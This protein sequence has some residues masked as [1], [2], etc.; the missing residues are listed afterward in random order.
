[1]EE[2]GASSAIGRLAV[3]IGANDS[4]FNKKMK[5][6]EQAFNR[7]A[8]S[9]K[10]TGETLTKAFTGPLAAVGGS[11]LAMAASAGRAADRLLDLQDITG[12]SAKKLQEFQHVA[13]VA[14]V[15]T[16]AVSN[17][18][19]NLTRRLKGLDSEGAKSSETLARL[20][21]KTHDAA[22]NIRNAGE[23][24]EDALYRLASMQNATERNTIAAELFGNS[25]KDLA[26]ILGM[27]VHGIE[28][29]REEAHKLG[30]VMTNEE[31]LNANKLRASLDVLGR[32][33]NGLKNKIGAELAPVIDSTLIPLIQ[34]NLIPALSTAAK[35]VAELAYKFNNLSERSQN[36]ILA[37]TAFVVALGPLMMAF[38]PVIKLTGSLTTLMLGL[39]RSMI[40]AVV[41]IGKMVA[42]LASMGFALI[43]LIAKIGLIVVAIGAL[44]A[45]AIYTY[46]NWQAF[47]DGFT[48]L[49]VSLK[50]GVIE[51]VAKM[52][53]GVGSVLSR[54]G[55]NVMDSAA[56]KIRSY[57]SEFKPYGE[58][59]EFKG[60]MESMQPTIDGVSNAFNRGKESVKGYYDS[61]KSLMKIKLP[62]V[63]PGTRRDSFEYVQSVGAAPLDPMAGRRQ[64]RDQDFLRVQQLKKDSNE[65]IA[66]YDA[67]QQ[68]LEAF[69]DN[70]AANIAPVI[71]QAMADIA[72]GF[73][74]ASTQALL[75]GQ[76]FK[77]AGLQILSALADLA[78]QVGKIAIGVGIA[79][80][81]IK[82]ALTSLN[83]AIAIAAG[84]ALVA[85]GTAAK[86]A[87]SNAA[88]GGSGGS[89]RGG[90][91]QAQP[92]P[93]ASGGIV[94][95]PTF[96]LVGEYSGAK[97]NPEVIA[98]LD[99]LK[100]I[101]TEA[102]SGMM[103]PFNAPMPVTYSYEGMSMAGYDQE[104][105]SF[106]RGSLD[107]NLKLQAAE[108]PGG[109]LKFTLVQEDERTRRRV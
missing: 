78:V 16:E 49:W 98:P 31:L 104:S 89:S 38:G 48:R 22:G 47:S 107:V 88:K 99:K 18:V 100:G 86:M 81:S 83:P 76:S 53:E 70:L 103:S 25:W 64:Q 79:V 29:L 40:T 65:V 71:S 30:L 55:V 54:F 23:I 28:Q 77:S 60:F 101:L 14:G 44:A 58:M 33:F 84:V 66:A 87:L 95:G 73:V 41:G 6:V 5:Q 24:T 10:K 35:Y 69:R 94:S 46:E 15:N 13:T 4:Q 91:G 12:M 93:F 68:R 17:A 67:T 8:A 109:S 80:D 7:H 2:S 50:N 9:F 27:G 102:F 59:A 105:M 57:K 34:E 21:I 72:G 96:A 75:S 92:V 1:M 3:I 19:E 36:I 106:G 62:D 26:P 39:G 20:G 42:S 82:K 52:A 90:A 85:L 63:G 61:F 56:E 74:E 43:P 37:T 11:F 51:L 32:Q 45:V 108:V 97:N